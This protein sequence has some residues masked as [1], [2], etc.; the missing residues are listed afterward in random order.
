MA[1]FP[2]FF[3]PLANP[4]L[5]F[6][7]S[8]LLTWKPSFG[9]MRSRPPWPQVTC[10]DLPLLIPSPFPPHSKFPTPQVNCV[11]YY[12]DIVILASHGPEQDPQLL[13]D[14]AIK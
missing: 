11:P 5:L 9:V 4:L 12:D 8:L 2:L 13:S 3:T 6:F 14:E 10:T 7:Y 1:Q